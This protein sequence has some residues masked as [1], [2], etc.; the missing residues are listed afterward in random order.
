MMVQSSSIVTPSVLT[1]LVG[2]G[3]IT[4]DQMYPLTLGGTEGVLGVQFALP[5]DF[6][7]CEYCPLLPH[8]H[9]AKKLGKMTRF[10]VSLFVF[11]VT[12][13]GPDK[14]SPAIARWFDDN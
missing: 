2:I 4:I 12:L 14:S 6:E 11:P 10:V 7:C 8:S 9:Y 13:L 1:P 5:F 3:A